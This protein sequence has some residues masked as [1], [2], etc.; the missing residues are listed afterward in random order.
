MTELHAGR[1]RVRIP[2]ETRGCSLLEDIQ[3]GF[4]GRLASSLGAGVI[5]QGSRGQ[6]LKLTTPPPFSVEVK[7]VWSYTSASPIRLNDVEPDTFTF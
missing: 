3:V 2:V 1:S 7:N 5:S 6:S 4:E